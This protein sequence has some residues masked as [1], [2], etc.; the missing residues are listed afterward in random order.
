LGGL[1]FKEIEKLRNSPKSK[2]MNS[3]KDLFTAFQE[4]SERLAV[5]PSPRAWSQLER[6]LDGKRKTSGTVV[7]LRWVTAMAAVFVLVVGVFFITNMNTQPSVAIGDEPRPTI[8]QDLV[9]TEGCNPYCL[10]IKER[11]SLPEYY[12]NPVRK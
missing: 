4:G 1:G 9:N 5:Q 8:L 12:A 6:R 3:R 11:K 7:L 10:L 2:K